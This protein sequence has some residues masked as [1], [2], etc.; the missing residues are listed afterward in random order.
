MKNREGREIWFG[1]A[2]RGGYLPSTIKGALVLFA[3]IAII[4]GGMPVFA[5][6]SGYFHLGKW[7]R[8]VL[9]FWAVVVMSCYTI[10]AKRHYDNW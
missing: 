4:L 10:F 3:A 6:V 7:D 1:K 2:S 9:L 5:V 8:A